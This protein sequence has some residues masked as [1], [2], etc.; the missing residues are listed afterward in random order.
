[1]SDAKDKI[2]ERLI[3]DSKESSWDETL[4]APAREWWRRRKA[5]RNSTK[6]RRI[7]YTRSILTIGFPMTV[8]GGIIGG[9]IA[10]WLSCP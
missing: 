5:R 9:L 2:A 6:I 1:M 8:I 10:R 4:P 3:R 7:G